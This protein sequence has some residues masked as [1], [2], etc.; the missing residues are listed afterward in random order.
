MK[1]VAL[2][3]IMLFASEANASPFLAPLEKEPEPFKQAIHRTLTV[4]SLEYVVTI[5]KDGNLTFSPN[6]QNREK[7][8]IKP[9]LIVQVEK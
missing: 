7:F 8:I 2:L 1:Y 5:D 3:A 9:I 4:D 6:P